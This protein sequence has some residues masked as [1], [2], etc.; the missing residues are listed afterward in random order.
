MAKSK[1]YRAYLFIPRSSL[2]DRDARYTIAICV[3]SQP[4]RFF[5]FAFL[6]R[7]LVTIRS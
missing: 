7:T 1:R 3:M 2:L 6:S 4:F 5:L